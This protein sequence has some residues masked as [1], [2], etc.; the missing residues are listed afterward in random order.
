[1]GEITNFKA[2]LDWAIVE[3]NLV[4]VLDGNYDNQ[5]NL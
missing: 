1:M 5:K 4:K 3:N 2:S